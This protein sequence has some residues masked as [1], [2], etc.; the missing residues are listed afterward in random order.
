MQ[1]LLTGVHK[2]IKT[3]ANELH[4]ASCAHKLFDLC[5]KISKLYIQVDLFK[6]RH[7]KAPAWL[8]VSPVRRPVN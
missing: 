8:F 1:G 5:V 3:C 6:A 2:I 7:W 4:V